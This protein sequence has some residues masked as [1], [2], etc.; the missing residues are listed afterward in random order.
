[1]PTTTVKVIGTSGDYTT[2]QGWEDACPANIVTTD[3]IWEGQ[4]KN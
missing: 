1:M 3:E 4:L 2:I